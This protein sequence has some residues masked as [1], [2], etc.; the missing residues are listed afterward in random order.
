MTIRVNQSQSEW[1]KLFSEVAYDSKRI[2]EAG[3]SFGKADTGGSKGTGTA[4]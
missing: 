4:S 3:I 2:F 1:N